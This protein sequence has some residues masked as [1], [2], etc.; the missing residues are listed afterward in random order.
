MRRAY[1]HFFIAVS[2]LLISGCATTVPLQS[3]FWEQRKG[4]RVG[5][6]LA[7]LPEAHA[8]RVGS[9]MLLDLAINK[10][11]SA[12]LD[13]RMRQV[14]PSMLRTVTDN[15]V[16]QLKRL[17]FDAQK[18]SEPI[19][20]DAFA[21]STSKS[22]GNVKYFDRDLSSL[23]QKHNIDLLL[24]ITVSRYGTLRNYYGFI[25]LGK[26]KALFDVRGQMID[27]KDNQLLWQTYLTDDEAT[28]AV[29][30]EWSEPPDYPN[31]VA[32]LEQAVNKSMAQLETKFFAT[33]SR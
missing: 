6:A 3:N 33:S 19:P 8:H 4:A 14:A 12:K 23:A 25:P 10:A 29:T 7:S 30:G 26:P 27:L 1:V 9:E 24:L 16:A 2:V 21:K 13:A 28:V 11:L 5:V 15:F 22:S 20:V 32:A 31:L 17:G 18:I